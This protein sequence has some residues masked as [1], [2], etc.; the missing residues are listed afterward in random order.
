MV[1]L[2]VLA[3]NESVSDIFRAKAVTFSRNIASRREDSNI[4]SLR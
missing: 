1:V 3:S 4:R 2:D